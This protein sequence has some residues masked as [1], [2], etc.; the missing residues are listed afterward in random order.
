MVRALPS[1]EGG[2]VSLSAAATLP[3]FQV[4]RVARVP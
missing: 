3:I 4:V 2:L 1:V